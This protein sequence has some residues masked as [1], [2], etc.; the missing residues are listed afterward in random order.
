MIHWDT[1]LATVC[2]VI[3]ADG[4]LYGVR[5]ILHY[6]SRRN[7]NMIIANRVQQ[8]RPAALDQ[9]RAGQDRGS[10]APLG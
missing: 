6:I 8:M 1:V 4:F 9:Y 5:A 3:L 10:H 7:N 2:G